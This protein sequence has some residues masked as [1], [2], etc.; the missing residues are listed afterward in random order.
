MKY[1][2]EYVG[3]ELDILKVRPGIADYSSMKFINLDEIVGGEEI[4]DQ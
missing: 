2:N 3:E 4:L 1:I